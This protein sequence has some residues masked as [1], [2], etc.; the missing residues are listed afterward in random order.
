MLGINNNAPWSKLDVYYLN[1]YADIG[2]TTN[3]IAKLLKRTEDSIYSKASELKIS[4]NP[5]DDN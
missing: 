3:E 5:P 4:L 2:C 1:K